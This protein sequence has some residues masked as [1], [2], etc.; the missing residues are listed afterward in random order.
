MACC[1]PLRLRTP[2]RALSR[3]YTVAPQYYN[4]RRL[5]KFAPRHVYDVVADVD[6]YRKFVPWCTGSIVNVRKANYLE[7]EL[8]V[9][10]QLLSESY[11]SCV[12]LEPVKSVRVR[13]ADTVALAFR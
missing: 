1:K 2:R 5:L 3:R 12:Y 7:A 6:N 13:H 4:E 11:V 8:T 10:F 9:G